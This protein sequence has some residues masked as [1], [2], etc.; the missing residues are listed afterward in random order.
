[1][2]I[3]SR[4]ARREEQAKIEDD[5]FEPRGEHERPLPAGS[6]G[7]PRRPFDRFTEQIRQSFRNPL[8]RRRRS[9]L[10]S[11]NSNRRLFVDPPELDDHLPVSPRTI[12]SK[13]IRA[14][15]VPT[16]V[17]VS[18]S[19]RT[20]ISRLLKKS[21]ANDQLPEKVTLTKRIDSLRR[22]FRPSK[23]KGKQSLLD[24]DSFN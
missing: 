8:N 11:T 20:R 7:V 4:S 5:L 14:P 9:R 10:E 21:P 12:S 3:N 2:P 6:T 15:L 13:P 1:M 19:F 22:S 16:E 24:T 18:R 23:N 17:N